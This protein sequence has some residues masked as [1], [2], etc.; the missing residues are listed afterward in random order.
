MKMKIVNLKRIIQTATV[1]ALSIILRHIHNRSMKVME[2]NGNRKKRSLNLSAG[3]KIKK[4][5]TH[6]K[7]SR[8]KD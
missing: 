4:C 2:R 8:L 7:N 1:R 5:I 6:L 3:L